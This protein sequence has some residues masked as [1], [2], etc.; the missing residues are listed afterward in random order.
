MA[1][2]GWG[3][4]GVIRISM[5]PGCGLGSIHSAPVPVGWHISPSAPTC[6]PLSLQ[7]LRAQPLLACRPEAGG[8]AC[9]HPY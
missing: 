2:L 3:L 9:C 7:F 5:R 8:A 4:G 6:H 1:G